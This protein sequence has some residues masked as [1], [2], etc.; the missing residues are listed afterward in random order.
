M[1][2]GWR[3]H[4]LARCVSSTHCHS[5]PQCLISGLCISISRSWEH[6]NKAKLSGEEIDALANVL[7]VPA[8]NLHDG[9]GAHWWP[10]RGLGTTPPTDPVIYRLYEVRPYNSCKVVHILISPFHKQGCIGLRLSHQGK[11]FLDDMDRMLTCYLP[12]PSLSFMRRFVCDDV[13][14]VDSLSF[15]KLVR[16]WNHVY[17]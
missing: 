7:E 16:R 6:I 13:F 5:L 15:S 12:S 9:L 11:C 10:N 2:S 8:S 17:D 4:S 3:L 14:L 1:R